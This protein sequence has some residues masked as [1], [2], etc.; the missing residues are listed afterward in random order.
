MRRL[1]TLIQPPS[2]LATFKAV[3][4]ALVASAICWYFGTGVWKALMLGCGITIV[5][6][7]ALVGTVPEVRDLRW[8]GSARGPTLGSRSDVSNLA[9]RLRGSWGRVDYSVQRR[10]RDI[11]RRRLGLE[12]LD[13]QN[14][15]HRPYIEQLIG[16]DSYDF[17]V[18]NQ[19]DPPKLRALL[20]CL[21]A[22]DAIDPAYEATLRSHPDSR[23]PLL[24][25]LL[26]RKSP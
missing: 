19:K 17:L 23:F 4:L 22:L 10:A 21:D 14:A 1:S 5:A 24:T 8:R 12:G 7:V 15:D 25:R 18:R 3:S 6:L 2:K 16:A 13:L 11:A 9:F 26:Q 20:R